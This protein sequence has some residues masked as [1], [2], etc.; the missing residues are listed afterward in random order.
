M[1][2]VC[3]D[4]LTDAFE[5]YGRVPIVKRT[6]TVDAGHAVFRRRGEGPHWAAGGLVYDDQRRVLLIRNVPASG[7]G[8]VW[9]APGGWLEEGESTGDGFRRELREEVGLEVGDLRL[10]RIYNEAFTDGSRVLH[11][12]FAQFVAPAK[13][14]Q[15]R[16][17]PDV[18]EA[19]WFEVQPE[20]MAFREDYAEDFRRVVDATF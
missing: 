17:A 7:W 20:A 19:A 8:D 15:V 16:L 2:G 6:V 3:K 13:S 5:R 11:A 12:Y 14:T 10:T 18:R 9:V 1:P 4:R